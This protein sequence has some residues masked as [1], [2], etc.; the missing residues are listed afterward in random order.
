MSFEKDCHE[1]L[2]KLHWATRAL[3]LEIP[4]DK[5]G[6][7]AKLIVQTMTGPWRYF[8]APDHVFA[9]GNSTDA[10]E[11]LAA[12]FHDIVYAH[13]DGSI[14]F[15]LTY[16]V[17]PFIEEDRGKISIRDRDELPDDTT[18]DAIAALFD[19]IP[20]QVLSPFGGQ[21]EFLSAV[22][23]AKVF[24]PFADPA[25]LVQ[26]GACIEATIPFRPLSDSGLSPSDLLY[27]RLHAVNQQFDL[28][29]SDEAIAQTVKR[30]VRMSNRDVS[31]FAH[32]DSAVFLDNT[33]SLL[34]ETNHNLQKSGSYTVRDY[35]TALEKMA[36]FLIHLEPEV[37]FAR[38]QGEPDDSM[39]EGLVAQAR[40]NLAVGRLYLQ[41]K[42]AAIA[43]L[44]ALSLRIGHDVS[45]AI[46]VGE[47]P[48]SA[49]S[50][51]R[52]TDYL[53]HILNPRQPNGNVERE[54]LQLL[55]VGRSQGN[56]YDLKNSPLATFMV[57]YLGFEKIRQMQRSMQ[58]FFQGKMFSETF[59]E[60]C[61]R[62]VVEMI[63]SEVTKLLD[64]R[65]AAIAQPRWE[66]CD[67][68]LHTTS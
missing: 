14:N 23:V 36:S 13:V 62:H 35:R 42:L 40:K 7:I 63:A 30:A 10:I 1:C 18:F 38:F 34:P 66:Y 54:V 11:V 53:P 31:G 39:Y 33:W 59:L 37:I 56:D 24:E 9:V 60:D 50:I 41:S 3:N 4:P 21:N 55:E 48:D 65:K 6:K 68:L 43:I 25:L 32:P 57:R 64:N 45:L 67:R 27:Q 2:E 16:Y 47:L 8:H 5:L 22:V 44:E 12:L 61:D 52:L 15:N 46:M 49:I 29:L 51:G 28:Q 19:V 26:I 17:A 20:G 58:V